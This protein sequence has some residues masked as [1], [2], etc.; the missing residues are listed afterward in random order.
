M[1]YDVIFFERHNLLEGL[2]VMKG[3][4][5]QLC[6]EGWKPQGGIFINQN[7]RGDYQIFQA[8]IKE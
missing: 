3:E 4:V 5:Q 2:D 7:E 6:D 8:V 1:K